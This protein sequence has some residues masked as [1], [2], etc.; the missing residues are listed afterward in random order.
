MSAFALVP[1]SCH[2]EWLVK[3]SSCLLHI[4]EFNKLLI[5]MLVHTSL[6][7]LICMLNV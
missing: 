7:E 4:D 6:T 5:Y 3:K 2:V 1:L